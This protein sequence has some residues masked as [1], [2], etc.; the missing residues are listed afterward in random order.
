MKET[1]IFACRQHI[2]MAIDDFVNTKEAAPRIDKTEKAQEDK[3]SYCEEAAEYEIK[4]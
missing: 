4:A 1:I 3:C 2:E